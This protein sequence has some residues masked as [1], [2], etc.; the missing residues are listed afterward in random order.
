MDIFPVYILSKD[1]VQNKTAELMKN[2]GV[3]HKLF[4]EPQEVDA[5]SEQHGAENI[6]NI[7]QNDRGL[8][9]VRNFILDYATERGDDWF[10]MLDDD[11]GSFFSREG[12]RT[13]KCDADEALLGAQ[14]ILGPGKDAHV[15]QLALEY[16]QFAW[17]AK[18]DYRTN[19][20]ADCV[21]ALNTK[22]LKRSRIRYDEDL[23]LK[24]DRDLTIQ[25][26]VSGLDVVRVT[27]FL[28]S[29]PK[30]GSNAGGLQSVYQSGVEKNNSL[31]LAKK[32]PAFCA[33]FTKR[34]GRQDVKISWNKIRTE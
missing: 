7:K 2:C 31:A 4:V 19:S 33:P 29:T 8:V 13:K 18:K 21:V 25:I 20:Y 11:I 22:K 24:V 26:I 14:Y 30:N 12:T 17:S 10:W 1:R 6:V 9:Y 3:P 23:Q 32:W 16:Q 5:Y 15:G 34:D 28:F 27:R